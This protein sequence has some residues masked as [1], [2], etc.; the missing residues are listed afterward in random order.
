[1]AKKSREKSWR[2]NSQATAIMKAQWRRNGESE[3]GVKEEM[4][5]IG[6]KRKTAASAWRGEI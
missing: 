5:K 1:M 2:G 3:N 4:K 6:K